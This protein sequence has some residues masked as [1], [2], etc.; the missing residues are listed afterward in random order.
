MDVFTMARL[1]AATSPRALLGPPRSV[2]PLM[3]R[4]TPKWAPLVRG[5]RVNPQWAAM[6]RH[7]S[8]S[9]AMQIRVAR[10]L[11]ARDIDER[12][13]AR[14]EAWSPDPGPAGDPGLN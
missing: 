5:A 3:P 2:P 14:E 9:L 7:A 11:H 10:E 8:S 12:L 4:L 13:G 1:L 6:A